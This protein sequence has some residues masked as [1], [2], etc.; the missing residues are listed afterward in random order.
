[1]N[2]VN[3]VS[4]VVENN[5]D[6]IVIGSGS[7]GAVIANRLSE[8]PSWRILLLETGKPGNPLTK[9]PIAAPVFQLTPYNWNYTMEHQDGFCLA[10]KDQ[11]CAWPRGKALGGT[12]VINYMIYTRGNPKDYNKWAA[13][14]NDGWSYEEVLPYFLKS[15]KCNLGRD[16]CHSPYHNTSGHLSVEFPFKSRITDAFLQA[17]QQLGEKI[18]DYNTPDFMGFAQIQANIKFGK[19]HSVADAFIYPI[20]NSRRNLK[21]LTSARV[22]K[23]LIEPK[24]KRAYGVMFRKGGKNFI[25]RASREVIL[26]AGTFNSPQLLMLSGIGPKEH[27]ESLKIPLIKN[28]PVGQVL[29]DHIAYL[30][31]AFT[32][33][34]TVEP[35]EALFHPSELFNWVFNGTGVY[36]SLA[37]VEAL[38]Y[39][40]TGSIPDPKYPDIELIFIGTGSLQSDF[41]LVVANEI[42]L[43]RDIYNA[44]FK[45]IENTPSWSIIPML[46]HPESRGYLKLRSNNPYDA[47]LLYGN[48]FTDPGGK[49][50]GT[51]IAAIRYIQKLS[52]TE[53]FQRFNSQIHDVPIPGCEKHVFDSDD[54]WVCAVRSLSSTLHHQV[55]TCKMGTAGD[56]EA[57]VD[58]RLRVHGVGGLRVV[59]SSVIPVTI[60]AHTN[61]PSIMMGEKASDII[62]EDWNVL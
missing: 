50:L 47:P 40:N 11:I 26:S 23:I 43:R 38:A 44:V 27:L 14:G 13:K 45:P 17:G 8:I 30:G 25:V 37:G 61:A 41:G 51:F 9:V 54:Y 4:V 15:E 10:M 29:Y 28:L 57:V 7:S 5:Y 58:P 19:R 34:Q 56:P 33:N 42:R 31:L 39:I 2:A 46:L 16:M 18:V 35:R 3:N 36:T 53:A 48:F 59:D 60:S 49:D 12:T 52:R 6:F 55:G 22:T 20:V 1:L 32:I 24:T 21:V 62:K